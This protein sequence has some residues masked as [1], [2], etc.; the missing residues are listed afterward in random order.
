MDRE[1]NVFIIYSRG[2]AKIRKVPKSDIERGHW[3]ADPI[4]AAISSFFADLTPY[5]GCWRAAKVL[6]AL[7]LAGVLG[8]PLHFYDVTPIG[9][10]VSRFSKDVD[11]LDTSLP[12]QA[13][14]VVYCT[15][16]VLG[17]LFV[18]SMSTPM[19][20]VVILPIGVVYYLIQRFYVSSSRQLKRLESVSRSPIYSHFGESITGASTIRAYAVADRFIWESERGVDHN[21]SCYY[22]SCIANRWLAIR[23]EMIGNLII[24]FAALFAVRA[25]ET[26]DPGLVGLS[27][28]YALQITQTLNWLVRMTSEVETNIVAVERIKEYA[29]TK[30]EA[31]WNLPN[32]PGATWPETGALQLEGLSLGYRIGAEP[33]LRSITCAIA[34]QEKIGI[35][36]RTGAGKSTLTLGLFR[37]VEPING[38]ILIDGI[39]ISTIGLHQLR[40]RI[41]IIP[42]DPVLFSGTLRLNLDPFEVHTDEEIWQ[43]LEHAHL[44]SF[45]Q[46]LSARLRHEIAEGGENLSVGQRQLV[47]LARA[48]LRKTPLLV[49]DEATAAVDLETDQL[50]QNTIRSEFSSCTVL[51]IAHRL[52]TIMDSTRVMVLDRG[53]LVEFAS[54][55]QLLRDHSSVFYGMAKDAG[56]VN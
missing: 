18:I 28:T 22:P 54:P 55:D 19:F 45:V 16:E 33:A 6:H 9:R 15:F 47:C 37:I 25:R 32:G 52:N 50:I 11:V 42:Q 26:I 7:L 39:D 53:Q 1:P 35:V 44:K 48:L 2:E 23:L 34:P 36:G 40:S 10:I 21:Q 29:E 31:A 14:D 46:G 4:V 56:L 17:T 41:T 27:I 51:T 24:F 20:L 5:L 38:K 13:S 3:C 8:A 12:F 43:S 30:Q 49:L